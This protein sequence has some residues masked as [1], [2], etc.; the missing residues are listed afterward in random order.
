MYTVAYWSLLVI[1]GIFFILSVVAFIRYRSLRDL[2]KLKA[3]I[4]AVVAGLLVLSI[5]MVGVYP[6]SDYDSVRYM[7]DLSSN[8]T[9]VVILP[10]PNEEALEGELEVKWGDGVFRVV[11]SAKGRGL[12]VT[13]DEFVYIEG[14]YLTREDEV[15]YDAEL[16]KGEG[17]W[18]HL[19]K[20]AEN[21]TMSLREVRIIHQ[22]P[23]DFHSK[24]IVGYRYPIVEG[25]NLIEWDIYPE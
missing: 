23:F 2:D 14:L 15:D 16:D 21:L 5:N 6:T 24:Q 3:G 18:I 25:W 19:D 7:A 8:G 4:V 12:E 17:F 1:S 20:S 9:C 10:F 11:E 13:F 22:D